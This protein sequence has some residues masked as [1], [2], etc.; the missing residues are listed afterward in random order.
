MQS[1][2]VLPTSQ[3]QPQQSFMSEASS[4]ALTSQLDYSGRHRQQINNPSSMAMEDER[5]EENGAGMFYIY[6]FYL[7]LLLCVLM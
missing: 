7:L 6:S 2:P 4:I 5:E 1:S 3:Q